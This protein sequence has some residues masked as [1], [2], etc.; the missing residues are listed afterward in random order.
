MAEIGVREEHRRRGI[1][2]A[3]LLMN[4]DWL[5]SKGCTKA[6]VSADSTNTSALRLYKRTGFRAFRTKNKILEKKSH[7]E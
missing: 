2:K 7:K 1:G 6:T 4:L 5:R 3:M